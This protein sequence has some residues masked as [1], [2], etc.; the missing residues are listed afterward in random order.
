MDK[1]S[2]KGKA[3]ASGALFI[4]AGFLAGMGVGFLIDNISAGMFVGLGAGFLAYALVMVF[5]NN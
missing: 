2:N 1:D 5:K 3:A 4:P